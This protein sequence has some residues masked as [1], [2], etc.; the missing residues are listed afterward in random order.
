MFARF[1]SSLVRVKIMEIGKRI[2]I[3]NNKKYDN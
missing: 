1:C 2:K 3:S